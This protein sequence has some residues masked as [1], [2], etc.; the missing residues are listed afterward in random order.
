VSYYK[1]PSPANPQIIVEWRSN[2]NLS[3]S[4]EY[5]P[6][7]GAPILEQSKSELTQ[8]HK[9]SLTGLSDNTLYSFYVFGRDEFGNLAK[10]DTY[11]LFTDLDARPA[12]ISDVVIQTS[13]IG[14]GTVDK[15]QIVVLFKTDEPTTAFVEYGEGIS[16]KDFPY[17]TKEKTEMSEYHA[18]T[19]TSLNPESLYHLRINV[20]DKG[21][22]LTQSKTLLGI[23]GRPPQSAMAIILNAFVKLLWFVWA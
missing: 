22:N 16:D 12:V 14:E 6:K 2:V 8:K 5:R 13:N 18:I 1:D 23:P 7:D 20:R 4:I 15:S 11:T 19:L 9:A 17:K 21:N 3:T 10:S